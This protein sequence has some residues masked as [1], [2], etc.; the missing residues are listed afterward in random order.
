MELCERLD[1]CGF[2][3]KYKDTY[4][5]TCAALIEEYCKNREKSKACV[6]KKIFD[7]T[8]SPPEDDMLPNGEF[9]DL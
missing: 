3:K 4:K 8:G 2:F 9:A 6:R 1:N 5:N 7:E